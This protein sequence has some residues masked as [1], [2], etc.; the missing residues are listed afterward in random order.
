MSS[1]PNPNSDIG[2]ASNSV[3]QV[4][5]IF[6]YRTSGGGD[7]FVYI[8]QNETA[9]F[10]L[11][12]FDDTSTEFACSVQKSSGAPNFDAETLVYTAMRH[13]NDKENPFEELKNDYKAMKKLANIL[14]EFF[15]GE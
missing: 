12:T 2:G 6:S 13:W 8:V 1:E 10:A 15:N 3:P 7:I 11:I 5:P 4:D 9:S 14:A